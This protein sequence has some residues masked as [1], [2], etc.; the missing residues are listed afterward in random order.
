MAAP[1]TSPASAARRFTAAAVQMNSGEDKA[2]NLRTA[3]CLVEQAASRGA[4]LVVLPELFNCLGRF[5][6]VLQ[7]AETVPG[8]TSTAMSELARRL[9]ITLVAGSIAERDPVSGKALNTSLLFGPD[10]APLATYRKIHLFEIGLPGTVTV[11]ESQWLAPGCDIVN[12]STPLGRLGQAI[13]YDLRFPELFREQAAAGMDLLALPSAFTHAT[14]SAHWEILLRARAIEN[15]VFVIAANQSGSHPG[16]ISTYGHSTIID[17]WGDVLAVLSEEEEGIA[18]AEIDFARLH[19]VRTRLP[20]L[21][22]RVIY[23]AKHD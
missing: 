18:L 15:Q 4:A 10:G 19:E 3:T 20:A 7:Q 13:C 14:G 1:Q 11:T 8:E 12:C 23:S 6:E 21:K 22:N 5:T 9:R 17:P 16:N 2:A